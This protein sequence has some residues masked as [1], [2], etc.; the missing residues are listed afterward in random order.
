MGEVCLEWHRV[1]APWG[2]DT[3]MDPLALVASGGP[4]LTRWLM[5]GGPAWLHEGWG[6]GCQG[7]VGEVERARKRAKSLELPAASE[8]ARRAA[9]E[10]EVRRQHLIPPLLFDPIDNL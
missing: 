2:F 10:D 5:G 4:G 3:P 6:L 8:R 7:W 9:L 1:K